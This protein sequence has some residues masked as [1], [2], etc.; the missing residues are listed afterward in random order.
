MSS[1]YTCVTKITIIRYKVPEYRVRLTEF[2]VILGHFLPFYHPANDPQ[3]QNF[4]KKYEKTPLEILPFYIYMCATNED[5][6]IYGCSN[7]RSYDIQVL[8]YNVQQIE[9]FVILDRF[10]PLYR[11]MDP[12][13]QNFEKM[14]KSLEDIIILQMCAIN[15]NHMQYCS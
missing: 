4:E 8:K 1:F 11:P 7:I 14:K 9:F 15:D 6:M 10:L 13:N 12:E 2:F 3:N 5:H